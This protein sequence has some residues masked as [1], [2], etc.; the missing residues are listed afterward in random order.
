MLNVN[1]PLKTYFSEF[2]L[3]VQIQSSLVVEFLQ[4]DGEYS[5]KSSKR[6]LFFRTRLCTNPHNSIPKTALKH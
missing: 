6:V 2:V 3:G 1:Q 4:Y 5:P